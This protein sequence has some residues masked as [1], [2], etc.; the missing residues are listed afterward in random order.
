MLRF[1][2]ALLVR[3]AFYFAPVTSVNG[4]NFYDHHEGVDFRLMGPQ[5]GHRRPFHFGAIL[6]H[7][8]SRWFC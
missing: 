6:T 2:T 5:E 8:I 4:M 7:S 1:F 3:R